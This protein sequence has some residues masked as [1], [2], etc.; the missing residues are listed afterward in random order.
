MPK[1]GGAKFLDNV[2]LLF[3]FHD[4]VGMKKKS[5]QSHVLKRQ[6]N[7]VISRAF[8]TATEVNA[9]LVVVEKYATFESQWNAQKQKSGFCV[10]Y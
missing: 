7:K 3:Q 8:L 5:V 6:P 2:W 4:I 1:T 10:L 9:L